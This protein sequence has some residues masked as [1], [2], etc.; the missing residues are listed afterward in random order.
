VSTNSRA[1]QV[2][3]KRPLA[4]WPALVFRLGARTPSGRE[5]TA[6]GNSYLGRF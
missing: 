2:H 5:P 1:V 6:T 3:L 4:F